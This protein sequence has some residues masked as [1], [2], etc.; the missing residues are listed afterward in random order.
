M[1]NAGT[2]EP[3]PNNLF[4]FVFNNFHPSLSREEAEQAVRDTGKMVFRPSSSVNNGLAV[5]YQLPGGGVG[6][7]LFYLQNQQGVVQKLETFV[8]GKRKSHRRKHRSHKRKTQ[9]KH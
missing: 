4:T 3:R 7:S 9:R 5:T 6:H 2:G 8:G 1:A